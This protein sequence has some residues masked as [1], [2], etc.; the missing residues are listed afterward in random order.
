MTPGTLLGLVLLGAL[1]LG[2]S[3]E[4]AAGDRPGRWFGWG[5]LDAAD[6]PPDVRARLAYLVSALLDPLR[7]AWGGPIRVT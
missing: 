1:A 6:A 7:D 4:L 2:A 5:E 3:G